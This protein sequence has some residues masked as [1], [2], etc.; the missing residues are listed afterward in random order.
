MDVKEKGA[1]DFTELKES[2]ANTWTLESKAQLLGPLSVRF[3]AKSS[4]Y[5]VVDDA[6]PAGFKV[7]SDYRTSLQL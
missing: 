4:G 3:A 1:N 7:G 5:P 2:P 6:I